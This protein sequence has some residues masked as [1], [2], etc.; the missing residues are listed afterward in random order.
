MPLLDPAAIAHLVIGDPRVREQLQRAEQKRAKQTFR[1][2]LTKYG[3]Y[4]LGEL[5]AS[6]M[7][8]MV[9]ARNA[10]SVID[11]LR[12]PRGHDLRPDL[13][14]A[15][16]DLHRRKTSMGP[17]TQEFLA[18]P[19][20][21]EQQFEVLRDPEDIPEAIPEDLLLRR[22]APR[23]F[24]RRLTEGELLRSAWLQEDLDD[25]RFAPQEELDQAPTSDAAS[26][27][28]DERP[29]GYL[30]LDASESM[31]SSRDRRDQA[32]RGLALAYLLSQFESGNPTV[33]YL[34]R[35][36]L[37]P[38]YG[39]ESRTDFEDAIA[40]VLHHDHEGMTNLQGTLG[41]LAERMREDHARVD[42]ALITD[43]VTRLTKRPF[44]EAHLHTFLVGAKPEEFDKFGAAQY[45]ESI[46]TLR[47]WSD[48]FF[49][50]DP[51]AMRDATIP[52]RE[53]A[54]QMAKFLH[55]LDDE[56]ENSAS[57][58]KVRRLQQR[59]ENA[60]A[61]V[62]RALEASPGDAELGDLRH[63]VA[64]T[65][66]RLGKVDPVQQ[67]MR[68]AGRWSKADRE[69]TL[70]LERREL[71]GLLTADSIQHVEFQ[72]NRIPAGQ[73]ERTSGWLI[74]RVLLRELRRRVRRFVR[75][76]GKRMPKP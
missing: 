55:G 5:T 62:E 57:P 29:F 25:L 19:P 24:L 43:G 21:S 51:D 46:L 9:A 3:I 2:F 72:W 37:S 32:A 50:L 61:L 28:V 63:R 65:S 66:E 47:S 31:G 13:G 44:G 17:A 59:A 4:D 73:R 68:N 35:G 56:L 53:D 27:R 67:S 7:F 76:W 34:F 48:S 39:G 74:L 10:A 18:S 38:P 12:I 58:E 71:H 20:T 8:A 6:Q 45:Q 42:I 40:A 52:R 41:K 16:Y 1:D 69:M 30:L 49:D 64:E 23:E 33:V 11:F 15:T 70:A 36:E 54:I 22:L 60:L 75:R 14:Q 26:E